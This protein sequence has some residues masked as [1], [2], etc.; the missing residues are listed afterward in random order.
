MAHRARDNNARLRFVTRIR[1]MELG[2]PGDVK[3]GGK[4]VS[5]MR[6]TYGPGYRVYFVTMGSTIVVRRRSVITKRDISLA[7][8]MTKE[9]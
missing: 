7:K 5:E 3:A 4:G 6:I 1:R 8:Q 2:N 9:I